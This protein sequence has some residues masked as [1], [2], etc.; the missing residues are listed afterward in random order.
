MYVVGSMYLLFTL[1]G[2]WVWAGG[3]GPKGLV[4][5]L[6][7]QFFTVDISKFEVSKTYFYDVLITQNDHPTYVWYVVGII[8]LFFSPYLGI[9]SGR[10]GGSQ[11]IGAKLA[12]TV[13]HPGQLKFGRFPNLFF[14]IF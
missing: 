1:F 4:H 5:N 10:G 11:G 3:G 9:G 6:R 13:F 8:Y 2:Y 7:M 14:L 12:H